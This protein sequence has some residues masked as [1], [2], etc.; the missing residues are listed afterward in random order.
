MSDID[1]RYFK[2]IPEEELRKITLTEDEEDESFLELNING[3]G[4]F[5]IGTPVILMG[6]SSPGRYSFQLD[7]NAEDHEQ[8]TE[9]IG[10]LR[11]LIIKGIVSKSKSLYRKSLT[12]SEIK[13]KLSHIVED[14]RITVKLKN[15]RRRKV[16]ELITR[17]VEIKKTNSG[18]ER[19]ELIRG[20]TV[21][22]FVKKY[23]SGTRFIP[24]YLIDSV[25]CKRKSIEIMI[26]AYELKVE[27][28]GKRKKQRYTHS[29]SDDDK[30]YEF[31]YEEEPV[32]AE[33][34]KDLTPSEE[35]VKKKKLTKR[36]RR[37]PDPEPDPEPEPEPE[38]EGEE[39]EEEG[40][41]TDYTDDE[42]SD[43]DGADLAS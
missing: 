15:V 28:V 38:E 13:K 22:S 12:R 16:K 25:I 39:T 1:I 24:I 21:S 23:P 14:G 29:D 27:K 42:Y 36:R 32:V 37:K 41:Y 20:V 7:T 3:N 4:L 31:E 40:E 17:I 2:D 26:G 30:P 10:F 33:L 5:V 8:F 9:F 6:K 43:Y 19:E 35:P 11:Y 34:K 18:N